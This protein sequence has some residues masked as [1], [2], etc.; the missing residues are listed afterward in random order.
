MFDTVAIK[1]HLNNFIKENW[2]RGRNPSQQ[3]KEGFVQKMLVEF[4]TKGRKIKDM[5]NFFNF[6]FGIMQNPTGEVENKEERNSAYESALNWFMANP[7]VMNVPLYRNYLE[8]NQIPAFKLTSDEVAQFMQGQQAQGAPT[9]AAEP[10]DA[11]LSE[12]NE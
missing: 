11:I 12:L 8:F 7:M 9:P 4:E 5:K 2:K 10:R 1:Y 6:D 3:E